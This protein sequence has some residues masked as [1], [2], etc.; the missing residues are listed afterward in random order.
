VSTSILLRT[1]RAHE[2][3]ALQNRSQSCPLHRPHPCDPPVGAGALMATPTHV[4]SSDQQSHFCVLSSTQATCCLFLKHTRLFSPLRTITRPADVLKPRRSHGK[5]Q[6]TA[7]IHPTHSHSPT[8]PASTTTSVPP[9][10]PDRVLHG[11]C[12]VPLQR[13]RDCSQPLGEHC[14]VTPAAD[15]GHSSA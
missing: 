2:G 5:S 15:R 3:S 4:T 12:R 14:G 8:S 7:S 13:T 10:R 6:R 1:P 9:S 11:G